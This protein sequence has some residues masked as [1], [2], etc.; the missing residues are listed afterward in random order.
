MSLIDALLETVSEL[1]GSAVYANV[2]AQNEG[3]VAFYKKR[4]FEVVKTV[5]ELDPAANLGTPLTHCLCLMVDVRTRVVAQAG[6]DE[7]GVMAC[8]SNCF[9]S[10]RAS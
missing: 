4:N 9:V 6:V 1:G 7:E 10:Y 2:E 8:L 5:K 3:A